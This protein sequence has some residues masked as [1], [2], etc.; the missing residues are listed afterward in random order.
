MDPGIQHTDIGAYALGLLEAGDR[1]R[2]EAHVA[3]CPRCQAELPGL[4]PVAAALRSVSPEIAASM[5]PATA[6]D[7]PPP[8]LVDLVR[9]RAAKD[10]RRRGRDIL[11]AAAIGLVVLA[12]GVAVGA[13]VL[14]DSAG[15]SVARPA[16]D[17]EVI[18]D[19]AVAPAP[20][21][22]RSATDPATGVTGTVT[23]EAAAWGTQVGLRLENVEGPLEC[24]LI[25]VTAS[26]EQV[27]SGWA[28]PDSGYGVE[29]SPDPLT[30]EGGVASS[31]D[32]I[33]RLDVRTPDG[34]T[35]LSIPA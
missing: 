4:S 23:M 10:R 3:H 15:D 1:R 18:E 9:R 21:L 16:D 12:G 33:T 35:L 28:V 26:G 17:S 2:F 34:Q 7:P 5:E 22:Q 13:A 14:D 29:G 24:E 6:V 8:Q 11:V 32:D 30:V 31:P 27:V 20:V 25:A 19:E